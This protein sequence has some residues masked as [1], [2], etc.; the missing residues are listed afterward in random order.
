M[1]LAHNVC[2]DIEAAA[3][4]HTN[5]DLAQTELAAALDDLF[6]GGDHGLA[7]V[8]AETFGAGVFS[9]AKLFE[10][11][12]FDQL[13][14]DGLFAFDGEVNLFFFAFDTFLNPAFLFGIGDVHELHTN[15]FAIGAPQ[16]AQDLAD[17]GGLQAKHVVE[18]N[19]TV[20]IRFGE[21]VGLWF[22]FV[23]NA[24]LGQAKWVQ[25]GSQMA[26]DAIGADQHQGAYGILRGAN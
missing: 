22:E 3:V 18:E 26:H 6:Q 23:V 25:I 9:A 8:E 10:H 14:H 11:F 20:K 1:R 21:T 5:D 16:D 7:A 13:V 15:L 2:E 4:G 19:G 12:C 24:L 17:G